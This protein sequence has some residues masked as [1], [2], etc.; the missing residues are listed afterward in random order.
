MLGAKALIASSKRTWSL[1]LPVQP[2]QMASAPSC[3][4]DFDDALGD[5]RPGEGGAQ[6]IAA[7]V[8]RARLAWWESR[9]PRRIPRADP[10]CSSLEAPVLMA[11]SSSPSSSLPWPT[12]AATAMTSQ[13]VVFLQPRNNDGRIQTARIRQNRL[14]NLAHRLRLQKYFFQ[15]IP[16]FE[17]LCKYFFEIW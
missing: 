9:S 17:F 10:L 8:H 5:D 12:S 13:L 16:H 1:P 4:C 14:L 2:W 11:F 6:Q 3:L 7:L 15:R